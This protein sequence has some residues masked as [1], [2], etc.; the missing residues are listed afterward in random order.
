[1]LFRYQRMLM[2]LFKVVL[3]ISRDRNRSCFAYN[4][5]MCIWVLGQIFLLVV[6]IPEGEW[7]NELYTLNISSAE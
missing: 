6:L 5:T 7:S 3:S 4:K 2:Y 1:M